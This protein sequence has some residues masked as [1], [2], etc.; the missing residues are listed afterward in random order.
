M[1]QAIFVR[2]RI[3]FFF[4]GCSLSAIQ[5]GIFKVQCNLIVITK[6]EIHL[7]NSVPKTLGYKKE[8]HHAFILKTVHDFCAY[9]N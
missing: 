3:F 2:Y 1:K 7:Q 6:P 5:E 8:P 4:R 9:F